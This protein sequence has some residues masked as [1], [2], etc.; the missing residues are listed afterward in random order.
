[1]F[2]LPQINTDSTDFLSDVKLKM[3][4]KI[5]SALTHLRF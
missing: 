5:P 2:F 4:K 1:M 3:T